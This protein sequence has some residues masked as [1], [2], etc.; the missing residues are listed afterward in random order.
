M[1]NEIP[2]ASL[3]SQ[4]VQVAVRIRNPPSSRSN[5]LDGPRPAT[6][7]PIALSIKSNSFPP[8]PPFLSQH[9]ASGSSTPTPSSYTQATVHDTQNGSAIVVEASNRDPATDTYATVCIN[10]PDERKSPKEFHFDKVFSA[11]ASQSQIYERMIRPIIDQCL[12]GYNGCI[13]VYGQTASGKTYTMQGPSASTGFE[14]SVSTSDNRGIILRVA[15]QIIE[16]IR[17]SKGI[18]GDDNA[19]MG[20]GKSTKSS[21]TYSVTASY[22][23]IYQEQLKDLLC[24]ADQQGELRIRIDSKSATGKELYVE[25]LTE[26]QL[27]TPLDYLKMIELGIKHRTVAETNMNKVS[28]RSHSVLTLIIEQYQAIP[29]SI[30]VPSDNYDNADDGSADNV[31]Q[32]GVKKRSK[33]HL[34]DLAGSERV[35]STGATGTRLKEGASINQSLS[36]LGNVINALSTHAKHVPYRDSKLTYLLS[37][38]LGG[39]SLTAM[40]ACISPCAASYDETVGTLRFA[41]RAKKVTNQVRVNVD[42]IVLRMLALEAEIARLRGILDKCTCGIWRPDGAAHSRMHSVINSMH[43]VASVSHRWSVRWKMWYRRMFGEC[44]GCRTKKTNTNLPSV[45]TVLPIDDLAASKPTQTQVSKKDIA[46]QTSLEIQAD[47]SNIDTT[48]SHSDSQSKSVSSSSTASA[49]YKRSGK[50]TPL[51]NSRSS[52]VSLK[53]LRE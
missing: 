29:H 10:D 43:S 40:I 1:G 22:L 2:D 47:S 53:N 46:V 5:V 50:I 9:I 45:K 52:K 49:K 28:S 41:E 33:I 8:K 34:I 18:D 30:A 37:D 12:D 7:T 3:A 38:S 4:S 19:G 27:S 32:I 24:P 42:P 36:S 20:G 21:T 35:D 6:S 23:E 13:F 16:C 39:N 15:D 44:C 51:P 26:R 17:K 31:N 14:E 48:H 11:T 25:G